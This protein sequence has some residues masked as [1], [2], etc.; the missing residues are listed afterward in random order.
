K[1]TT[2]LL[3]LWVRVVGAI[4][5]VLGLSFWTGNLVR[6]IPL[7]M[8]LGITIVLALWALATLGAVAHVPR[9][10]AAAGFA[11][12]LITP[13]LGVTQDGLLPGPAHW[14]IQAAHL[15]VGIGAIGLAESLARQVKRLGATH[16]AATRVREAVR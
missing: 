1:T 15:L 4:M 12:G 13:L 14:V 5:I 9:G 8:L 10:L 2:T 3:Q 11:W 6:L 7:H 16:Q